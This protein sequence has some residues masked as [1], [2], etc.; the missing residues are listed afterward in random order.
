L[1]KAASLLARGL[2]AKIALVVARVVP[3][4]LSLLEPQVNADVIQQALRAPAVTVGVDVSIWIHFC[5]DRN[6]AVRGALPP[7]STAIMTRPRCWNWEDQALA[8][9]LRRDGHQ[10]VVI[11]SD[12][13]DRIFR[14]NEKMQSS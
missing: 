4:P 13:G 1:L 5:R 8:R 11:D 7:G 10:L 12:G 9:Y 3:Y 2:D 6:H 14:S